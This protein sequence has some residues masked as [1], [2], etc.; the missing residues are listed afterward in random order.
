M[1]AVPDSLK[2]EISKLAAQIASG[3]M[4]KGAPSYWEHADNERKAVAKASVKLALEICY[5]VDNAE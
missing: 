5:E 2:L 4:S 3:M 1:S